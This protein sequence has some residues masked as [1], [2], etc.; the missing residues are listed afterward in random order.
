V[1]HEVTRATED[2]RLLRLADG[3]QLAFAECGAAR[4]TPVFLFHGLPGSR[5]QRPLRH[6]RLLA[7]EGVRLITT[8]RPGVGLSNP[9]PG[10]RLLDWADDVRQLA[11]ALGI[12]RFRVV[13]VSGGGPYALACA[14]A[15]R[16]RVR[17]AATVGGL[18]P[19][20]AE[21]LGDEFERVAC[22]FFRGLRQMPRTARLAFGTLVFFL[23][24]SP[25][26]SQVLLV[27]RRCTRDHTLLRSA[28]LRSLLLRDF[29]EATRQGVSG[30]LEDARVLSSPWGFEPRCV[31]VRVDV[32][33]GTADMVVR[34][35]MGEYLARTLPAARARFVPEGGHF[36]VGLEHLAQILAGLM[37]PVRRLELPT[38]C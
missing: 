11:D 23:R 15:L 8:D 6:E 19:F 17:A 14:F 9:K 37:E 26:P 25:L 5:Y 36:S 28:E 34:P 10:R 33:H 27:D 21:R 30:M 13:G 24:R 1:A 12:E 3:R 35:V 7:A 38:A 18:A 16:E 20:S 29:R 2:T 32:W 22:W 4:G 31:R